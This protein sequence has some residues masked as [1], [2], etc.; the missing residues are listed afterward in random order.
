MPLVPVASAVTSALFPAAGKAGGTTAGLLSGASAA[1]N[2]LGPRPQGTIIQAPGAP[3]ILGRPGAQSIAATIRPLLEL[4]LQ[5]GFTGQN[6]VQGPQGTG[7]TGAGAA[8]FAGPLS[9]SLNRLLFPR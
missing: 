3:P 1:K 4:L 2:L 8:P 7:L 5:S 6:P 9:E